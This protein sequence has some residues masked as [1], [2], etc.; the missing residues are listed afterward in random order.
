MRYLNSRNGKTLKM[1][2]ATNLFL[3]LLMTSFGSGGWWYADGCGE[4]Y[5]NGE[6][7][8]ACNSTSNPGFSTET[9]RARGMNWLPWKGFV[10][11]KHS[12]IM[13]RPTDFGWPRRRLDPNDNPLRCGPSFALPDGKRSECD[14]TGTINDLPC[15]STGGYCGKTSAH[16]TCSGCVDYRPVVDL[17]ECAQDNHGCEHICTNP[18]VRGPAEC[19]CEL[20]FTLNP[21]NKT[22]RAPEWTSSNGASYLPIPGE[23]FS[24]SAAEEACQSFGSHLASISGSQENDFLMEMMGNDAGSYWIGLNTNQQP[25]RRFHRR[26]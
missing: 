12:R 21:D 8:T 24:W 1:R 25:S 14:P 16:C 11:L 10:S 5:L 6:Y 17:D 15:C 2:T 20:G 4:V 3:C 19:S 13:M 22:C 23:L 18:I 26:Q 9:C 7:K